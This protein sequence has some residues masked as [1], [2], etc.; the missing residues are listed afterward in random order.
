L[1][2]VDP[3]VRM[4]TDESGY[5]GPGFA[6]R[7]D[8]YRPQPPAALLDLLPSLAGGRRPHLVVDLGSG[9]G[10]STRV[11]AG[12]A[13]EVIGVE[14]ND[15]MRAFAA[16]T[17]T[18]ANVRYV[19]ASACQTGVPDGPADL[20][21]GDGDRLLGF[22]LSEGSMTTLLASGVTEEE[23]GLDR[24]RRVAATMP[25][26]VPLV[27]RVPGAGRAGVIRH[28]CR[29]AGLP[30]ADGQDAVLHRDQHRRLHR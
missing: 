7:Y 13:D 14:P 2:T 9:T 15:A 1:S 10:L 4:V 12:H 5:N 29:T 8:R 17:T 22:G 26:P 16:R 27:D 6:E 21:T 28:C 24:L 3:E 25:D 23:V 20:V 30:C 11:W 19:A 18:A